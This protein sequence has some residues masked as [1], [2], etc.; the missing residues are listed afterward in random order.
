MPRSGTPDHDSG[1][2][3]HA[4]RSGQPFK[5]T[6]LRIPFPSCTDQR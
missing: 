3:H 2:A 6:V 4:Q 5:K 1:L